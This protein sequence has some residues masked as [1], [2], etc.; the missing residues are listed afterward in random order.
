MMTPIGFIQTPFKEKFGVPRQ[1]LLVEEALGVIEFPKNDF[2]MEAFRGIEA[3]S[4]LWLLFSFH[5][6]IEEGV[7]ALIRPPRFSGKEKWGVFA[8][9][10]PHRP[11]H[12]GLSAVKFKSIEY[13]HHNIQLIVEGVDLVS[14]TP[15]WDIKP[16]IPYSDAHPEAK[17]GPFQSPPSLG[18][19]KWRADVDIPQE[20]KILIEK[21]IALD[22]R[23]G[24]DQTSLFGVSIAGYNVKFRAEDIFFIIEDV[25]KEEP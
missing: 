19:V 2:F 5:L 17:C 14:G 21:V 1:P 13:G 8:S 23:P 12:L 16:Y 3:F 10:S 24:F 11:N 22:P 6:A 25:I 4:H 18:T 7:K 15:I 20:K 9:R